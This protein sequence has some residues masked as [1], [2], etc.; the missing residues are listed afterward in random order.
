MYMQQQQQQQQHHLQHQQHLQRWLDQESLAT[1]RT[2]SVNR[3]LILVADTA[4]TN[5]TLV[6]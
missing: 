3:P 1:A 6:A 5:L 4:P 2:S